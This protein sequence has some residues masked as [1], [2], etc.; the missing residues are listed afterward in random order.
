V[1]SKMLQE[2]ERHKCLRGN[3]EMSTNTSVCSIKQMTLWLSSQSLSYMLTSTS[4]LL[5]EKDLSNV[6][7]VL[8]DNNPTAYSLQPLNGPPIIDFYGEN[9]SDK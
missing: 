5:S 8:L 1:F 7:V 2:R 4:H 9:D 6:N 3:F